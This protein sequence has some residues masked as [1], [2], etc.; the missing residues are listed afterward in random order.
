MAKRLYIDL[1][2]CRQCTDCQAKCSYY[3]HPFNDGICSLREIAEFGATCRQCEKAPCVTGCPTE[4]LEK[5][6]NGVVKRYNMRCV[7]CRTCAY[8]CPFGTILPEVIPYA[9]SRCDYCIG[10]L[11]DGELPVCVGGCTEGAIEYGDFEPDEKA[12]RFLIGEHLV[13]HTVPWKKEAF[14]S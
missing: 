6:E 9:V 4:A 14:Q 2:K 13:V 11:K 10:R 5:Q 12:H 7:A 3:Y 8:A 1:V